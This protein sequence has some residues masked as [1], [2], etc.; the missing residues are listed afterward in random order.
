MPSALNSARDS[1]GVALPRRYSGTRERLSLVFL[2]RVI[3]C[4]WLAFVE[5]E[6]PRFAVMDLCADGA[7]DSAAEGVTEPRTPP[8]DCSGSFMRRDKG[9]FRRLL[10]QRGHAYPSAALLPRG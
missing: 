6:D 1:G 2:E 3:G 5:L 7:E 9:G 8:C 10:L 4:F